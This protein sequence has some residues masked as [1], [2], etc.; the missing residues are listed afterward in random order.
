MVNCNII[1]FKNKCSKGKEE[2]YRQVIKCRNQ[3]VKKDCIHN[4]EVAERI[5]LRGIELQQNNNN[6][7]D[8]LMGYKTNNTVIR[9]VLIPI[10]KRY[11]LPS[12]A[13]TMLEDKI[14]HTY[15]TGYRGN[16]S[17]ITRYLY[18]N[19]RRYLLKN[20]KYGVSKSESYGN[21]IKYIMYALGEKKGVAYE[22]RIKALK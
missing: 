5:G 17:K 3:K 16:L 6:G 4:I 9:D 13:V 15:T 14:Q 18:V 21:D 20:D 19:G 2:C 11:N 10:V 8:I 1:K 22:N 12:S 7:I